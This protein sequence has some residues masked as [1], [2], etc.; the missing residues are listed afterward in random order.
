[1]SKS[2]KL[3]IYISYGRNS[4]FLTGFH[5]VGQIT[6]PI[7]T[8]SPR[9][10]GRLWKFVFAA[11]LANRGISRKWNDLV[12][13]NAFRNRYVAPHACII[14]KSR[15][16]DQSKMEILAYHIP[17]RHILVPETRKDARNVITNAKKGIHIYIYIYIYVCVF[18][19]NMP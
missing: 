14:S 10:L 15:E 4:H 2:A 1:M 5:E 3:Y 19:H 7:R 18:I 11:L 12:R 13:A 16:N 6:L 17:A 9:N 8:K